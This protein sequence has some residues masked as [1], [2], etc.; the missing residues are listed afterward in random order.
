MHFYVLAGFLILLF[1]YDSILQGFIS[2]KLF[3]GIGV[4]FTLYSLLNSIVIQTIHAFNSHALVVQAILVI[5]LSLS[6][7]ILL[8]NDIVREQR[9]ELIESLNWINSGLFIYYLSSLLIFYFGD[10]LTRNFSPT[11]NQYT[12]ALH[13]LFSTAMY[14][15]FF[16]GLWRRPRKSIS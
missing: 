2:R 10:F 13:T 6:T 14:T 1:F 11:I 9:V 16:I 4:L 8:L 5:I 3:V 7:Y 12:W 15:C